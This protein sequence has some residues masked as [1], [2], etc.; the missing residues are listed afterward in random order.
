M[1]VI[2]T[3]ARLDE[4]LLGRL[5][6]NPD[7]LEHLQSGGVPGAQ[8]IDI[9]KA[10]DGLVW[11]LSRVTSPVPPTEG[12]GFV[13]VRSLAPLLSGEGGREETNLES[14]Y[15]PARALRSEQVVALSEWLATIDT[16]RLREAYD[17]KAM[18]KAG[19]YP[20]IWM[21]EKEAA[22]EKY[23]LPHLGRLRAFLIDAA[24]AEQGVL[25]CFT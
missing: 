3:Y 7:W 25:V 21:R 16:D 17:P 9:D 12:A 23:L 20:Q 14:G 4:S 6:A 2:A 22:L 13:L 24:A 1:S 10:C 19:I 8:V 5:R 15:G 18:A 11:L